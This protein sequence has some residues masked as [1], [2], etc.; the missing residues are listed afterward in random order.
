MTKLS[1]VTESDMESLMKIVSQ[2][3][4]GAKYEDKYI[5]IERDDPFTFVINVKGKK[6]SK[7]DEHSQS[8]DS[9]LFG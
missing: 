6:E 2:M 7:K 1:N 5:T 3:P 8:I 9:V 4:V